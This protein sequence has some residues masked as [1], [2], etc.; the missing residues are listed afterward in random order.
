MPR[1]THDRAGNCH[2]GRRN[3][4]GPETTRP[5]RCYLHHVDSY[6]GFGW[7]LMLANPVGRHVRCRGE[8]RSNS[9]GGL[10]PRHPGSDNVRLDDKCGAVRV[11]DPQR[12]AGKY[13]SLQ[14]I[15]TGLRSHALDL[16]SHGPTNM[17]VGHQFVEHPK[18]FLRCRL[19]PKC[20]S[21]K[22]DCGVVDSGFLYI[23]RL[24]PFI[25]RSILG[26]CSSQK[27]RSKVERNPWQRNCCSSTK[28][29][30]NVG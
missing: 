30:Q 2:Q 16:P 28:T 24:Y 6:S 12:E 17:Y 26:N 14:A 9:V 5:L 21:A 15:R 1:L 23:C 4:G 8:Q 11:V 22:H 29:Q 3:N 25:Y 27:N 18:F 20:F 7:Q 19:K 13:D 10:L